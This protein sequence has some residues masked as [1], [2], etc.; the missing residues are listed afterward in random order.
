MGRFREIDDAAISR[1]KPY[2]KMPPSQPKV[3]D[4]N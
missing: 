3:E 4:E 1:A 2:W